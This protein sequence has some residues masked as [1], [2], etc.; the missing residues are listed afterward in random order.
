MGDGLKPAGNDG[1]TDRSM[2]RI[3]RLQYPHWPGLAFRLHTF[4][5]AGLTPAERVNRHR[6]LSVTYQAFTAEREIAF[7]VGA[8]NRH[9]QQV[10]LR[11]V[12]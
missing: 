10:C 7:Q 2:V 11:Y 8:Y 1:Q 6:T 3:L 12:R 9:T 4:R 5:V